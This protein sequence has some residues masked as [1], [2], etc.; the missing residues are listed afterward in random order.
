MRTI[1]VVLALSLM[2]VLT[3]AQ[4]VQI[5][6]AITFTEGPTSDRNGNVYFVDRPSQRIM[7][8]TPQGALSTYRDPSNAANGLVVDSENRLIA[9]EGAPWVRDW[10]HVTGTPRITRTDLDT[11][12]MEIL[13]DSYLGMPLTGPNDV[14]LDG[15]GRIYFTEPNAR[16]VYRVDRPGHIERILGPQDIERPNGIQISPDDATLYLVESNRQAGGARLIRAYDLGADGTLRNMRVHYNFSPGRSADGMSIDEAGNLYAAA[17]LN[18]LRG[19]AETLDTPAGVHV[20]SPGGE[21]LQMIPIPE[22][23]VTN[24][25]FG[26]PDMQ[27]LYITAGKTLYSTRT[28]VRG[29]AR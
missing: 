17:G 3:P 26:G 22:D 25:A 5:A 19:S 18:R 12:E 1:G 15:R 4:D 13:A 27:T 23:T 14:T 28:E 21:L 6:V 7:M 16:A 24:T 10:A 20:I 11:G 8:L 9:C 2:P 29:L